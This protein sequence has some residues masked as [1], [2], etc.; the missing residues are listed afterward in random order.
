LDF[1]AKL[2]TEFYQLKKYNVSRK[3][4]LYIKSKSYYKCN[5]DI[6]IQMNILLNDD[7][8]DDAYKLFLSNLNNNNKALEQ[9]SIIK[10]F[11]KLVIKNIGKNKKVQFNNIWLVFEYLKKISSINSINMKVLFSLT[12]LV[13]QER[14]WTKGMEVL[15]YFNENQ[16]MSIDKSNFLCL[17]RTIEKK[18]IGNSRKEGFVIPFFLYCSQTGIINFDKE[19]IRNGIFVIEEGLTFSIVRLLFIQAIEYIYKNHPELNSN[20]T[21]ENSNNSWW[22]KEFKVVLPNNIKYKNKNIGNENLIKTI[23][24]EFK[25][26]NPPYNIYDEPNRVDK[27]IKELSNNNEYSYKIILDKNYLFNW[28]KTINN[29]LYSVFDIIGISPPS[30]NFYDLTTLLVNNDCKHLIYLE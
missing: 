22:D 9:E 13:V 14:Q 18:D 1:L 15:K 7:N 10:L 29:N 25:K 20:S 24:E 11:E 21:T 26:F 12:R 2:T 4:L 5:I 28:I 23:A 27:N 19:G 16:K 17:F 3:I 8:L 30:N 6:N